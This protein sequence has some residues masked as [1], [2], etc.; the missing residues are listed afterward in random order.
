MTAFR[1][2][3][4]IVGVLVAVAVVLAVSLPEE[5]RGPSDALVSALAD[6]PGEV[7]WPSEIDEESAPAE[8][9]RVRDLLAVSEWPDGG[10]H[11]LAAGLASTTAA[12]SDDD[13]W[14][15]DR[16]R[17]RVLLLAV[18]SVESPIDPELQAAVLDFL[19]PWTGA[20]TAALSPTGER[21]APYD[22]AEL[23]DPAARLAM[24]LWAADRR[25]LVP[26][27]FLLPALRNLGSDTAAADDFVR[28]YL[29]WMLPLA[30]E[31]MARLFESGDDDATRYGY[32]ELVGLNWFT[33]A[34]DIV[35]AL[36]NEPCHRDRHVSVGSCVDE[37]ID[38]V[39]TAALR[40]TYEAVPVARLPREVVI[41]GERVP[42]GELAADQEEAVARWYRGERYL[43]PRKF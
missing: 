26:R 21:P 5:D 2:G 40:M 37:K 7:W 18:S 6:N 41:G 24:T 10:L 16:Q 13:G 42:W 43:G 25:P 11:R 22:P 20:M 31:E 15:N 32:G 39:G 34:A 38:R 35:A 1:R 27:E 33:P 12:L 28:R 30:R 23:D 8:V 29:A 17:S 3:V 36:A 9:D 19:Q 4:V 14:A